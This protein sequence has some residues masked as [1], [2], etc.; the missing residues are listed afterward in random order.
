MPVNPETVKIAGTDLVIDGT[1]N[2]AMAD[3]DDV[4]QGAVADAMVA[5]GAAGTI[6]AKLR[7]ISQDISSLLTG[8]ILTTGEA[9]IGK[10]GGSLGILSVEMTRP[11]DTTAYI[12]NDVVS[13]S[14]GA[15]TLLDFTPMMRVNAGT[16]YLVGA[17]LSTDKKSITPRFRVHLFNASNP[18]L[19]ADNAAWKEV[20]ADASKRLGYFDLP[21]MIT[22]ADTA[23]SNVSRAMD[24]TLRIPLFAAAASQHVYAA[25]ETLDAFT[26][27]SAEKFT[28]T[29]YVDQN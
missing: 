1:F 7:R 23:N 2:S 4:T 5:A 11:S 14:T 12:A 6:S 28:L 17:R 24:F 27:A 16:G 18:T 20:Y 10:I 3:G 15:T 9:H 26:P 19:A 21:G 22:A 13:D 25:L 29:L 8:I